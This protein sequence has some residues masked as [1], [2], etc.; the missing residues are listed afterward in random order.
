M[1]VRSVTAVR[2]LRTYRKVGIVHAQI[3]GT[4]GEYG[5]G[6]GRGGG[7]QD[8]STNDSHLQVSQITISDEKTV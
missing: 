2:K 1:C 6:P 4:L 7:H 8:M 3:Q 5:D